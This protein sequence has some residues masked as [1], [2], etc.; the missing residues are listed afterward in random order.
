MGYQ[1]YQIFHEED[2]IRLYE[3][4]GFSYEI[5]LSVVGECQMEELV[6]DIQVYCDQNDCAWT[7]IM[8]EDE[9]NIFKITGIINSLVGVVYQGT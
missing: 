6:Y 5:Y 8:K 9:A 7:A 1:I 2:W 4:P 3:V